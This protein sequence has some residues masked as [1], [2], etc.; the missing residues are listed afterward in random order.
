MVLAVE[1]IIL[2]TFCILKTS[3]RCLN[4]VWILIFVINSRAYIRSRNGEP[5][6]LQQAQNRL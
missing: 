1:I 5:I 2:R 4:Q 3:V 6:I